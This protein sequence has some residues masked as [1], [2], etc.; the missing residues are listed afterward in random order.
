M[1]GL[2]LLPAGVCIVLGIAF[3]SAMAGD[4][5]GWPF[6]L[7]QHFWPHL[8]AAA[9]VVMLGALWLLAGRRRLVAALGG[10]AILAAGVH[11]S[12]SAFPDSARASTELK[13]DR[14][15]VA[16]MNIWGGNRDFAAILG[17]IEE[18]GPDV[19]VMSEMRPGAADAL[20]SLRA[21]YPFV[22]LGTMGDLAIASRWP[23]VKLELTD[24][25]SGHLVAIRLELPRGP[26]LLLATHPV[27]PA[28]PQL[29]AKRDRLIDHIA[30]QV[31]RTAEPVIVAGDFNATPWSRPM[32]RLAATS[33]DYGPGAWQGTWPVWLPYPLG[34]A[35]DH[36]LAGKG[37]RVLHRR[38]GRRI[39]SDH[40]PV[41]ATVECVGRDGAV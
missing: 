30:D 22:A 18:A 7:A 38:H 24:P 32:R 41:L 27:V 21:R 4:Y 25:P 16:T 14:I 3:G 8:L 19:V 37:C 20:A 35:I 9:L 2:R 29:T 33:L 6:D 5:L 17:W 23:W 26:V 13:G 10:L 31:R 1:R 11:A 34:V 28:T 36:V 12:R 39:G 40:W 15:V